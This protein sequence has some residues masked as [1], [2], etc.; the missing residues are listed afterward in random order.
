MIALCAL[1]FLFVSLYWLYATHSFDMTVHITS[2]VIKCFCC[3]SCDTLYIRTTKRGLI[4]EKT[5]LI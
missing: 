4:I 1:G 3:D 5:K 2:I